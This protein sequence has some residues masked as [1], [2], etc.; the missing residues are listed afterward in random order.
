MFRRE[1]VHLAHLLLINVTQLLARLDIEDEYGRCHQPYR[2]LAPHQCSCKH[3][4]DGQQFALSTIQIRP[5]DQQGRSRSRRQSY[6]EGQV[7]YAR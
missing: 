3:W 6:C 2:W 4:T 1:V 5:A 7:V